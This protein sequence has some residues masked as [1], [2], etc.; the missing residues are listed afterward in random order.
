MTRNP[1]TCRPEE[2][3]QSALE[4]MKN[5]QVRRI[6]V[7]NGNGQ[8]VGIIS[9]A[10]VVTRLEGAEPKA[11]VVEEISKPAPPTAA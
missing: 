5:F 2:D 11:A 10:D 9:Q 8:L 7:V 6:P 4:G 3:V 1:F